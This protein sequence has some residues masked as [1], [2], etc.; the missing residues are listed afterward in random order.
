MNLADL[1]SSFETAPIEII[2]ELREKIL[3]EIRQRYFDEI[4]PEQWKAYFENKEEDQRLG[5]FL[6]GTSSIV[7]ETIE[8]YLGVLPAKNSRYL[9]GI[10]WEESQSFWYE[11]EANLQPIFNFIEH[12]HT[13]CENAIYNSFPKFDEAFGPMAHSLVVDLGF[14][15]ELSRYSKV[16]KPNLVDLRR[17]INIAGQIVEA[18]F[19]SQ[20]FKK[21]GTLS[22]IIKTLD[23]F[24][25]KT[26][27]DRLPFFK[28]F[29]HG[30]LLTSKNFLNALRTIRNKRNDYSHGWL[31]SQHV[32]ED[33]Q[34]CMDALVAER[35]GVLTVLYQ[36]LR[37]SEP[38]APA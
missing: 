14:Q 28:T 8:K 37:Q 4:D 31:D 23:S 3:A 19:F 27:T 38:E 24:T 32:E 10:L 17:M 2:P 13:K 36:V 26:N 22:D 6:D 15:A 1:L 9:Q 34:K 20:I 30:N 7:D 12:L 25:D 16:T 29:K 11:Q 5:E 33:F 18:I 21:E 35:I